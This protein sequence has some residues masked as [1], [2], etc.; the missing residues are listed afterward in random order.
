[1]GPRIA[2][3]EQ[4][5]ETGEETN[6]E[7]RRIGLKEERIL[8]RERERERESCVRMRTSN[9]DSHYRSNVILFVFPFLPSP[10]LSVFRQEIEIHSSSTSAPKASTNEIVHRYIRCLQSRRTE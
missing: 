7:K 9:L 1:M 5:K 4:N 6:V 8:G 10:R 3:V 2:H